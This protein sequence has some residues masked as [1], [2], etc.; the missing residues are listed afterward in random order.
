[1][2]EGRAPLESRTIGDNVLSQ[3]QKAEHAWDHTP[4]GTRSCHNVRRLS[5]PGTTHTIGVALILLEI[6]SEFLLGHQGPEVL[7]VSAS[8]VHLTLSFCPLCSRTGSLLFLDYS[9]I[10]EVPRPFLSAHKVFPWRFLM[11]LG[12]PSSLGG[13]HP[14]GGLLLLTDTPHT[15]TPPC[16]GL[17]SFC[18]L[19]SQHISIFQKLLFL[20]RFSSLG[21]A[22]LEAV[23]FL[24]WPLQSWGW[25]C[26]PSTSRR[27]SNL[28][29]APPWCVPLKSW[30]S[31]IFVE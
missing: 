21:Q 22:D 16:T 20:D 10:S 8:Q 5:T 4:L 17:F 31:R 29:P 23:I 14:P 25:R 6:K 2:S 12:S 30:C 15:P 18:D 19:H 24:R 9:I 7:A 13:R 11:V 3:C 27:L 28:T 26:G 1:M